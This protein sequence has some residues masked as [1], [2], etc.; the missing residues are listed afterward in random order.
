M[1]SYG[2]F[3]ILAIFGVETD[4]GAGLAQ[5]CV[6]VLLPDSGFIFVTADEWEF[7]WCDS[8]NRSKFGYPRHF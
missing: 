6:K 7:R 4:M 5:I 1:K 3:V 8:K 2:D